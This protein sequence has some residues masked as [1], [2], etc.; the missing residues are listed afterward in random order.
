MEAKVNEMD[1]K[2]D[3]LVQLAFSLYG[4]LCAYKL[5]GEIIC[6]TMGFTNTQ[7]GKFYL[8]VRNN[9]EMKEIDFSKDATFNVIKEGA[10]VSDMAEIRVKGS[11]T[12]LEENLPY[13]KEVRVLLENKSPYLGT[14]PFINNRNEFI[15]FELD[16]KEIFFQHLKREREGQSP[17]ILSL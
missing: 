9:T 8:I 5:N 13:Y 11:L 12:H 2:K 14:I 17:Y 6:K 10:T 16:S 3:L 1:I 7:E 4:V 15:L